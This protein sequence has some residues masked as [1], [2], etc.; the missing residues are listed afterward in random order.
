MNKKYNKYLKKLSHDFHKKY[1]DSINNRPLEN[2][3][4]GSIYSTTR[5]DFEK[6]NIVVIIDT[7]D[8]IDV[9]HNNFVTICPISDDILMAT[10]SD[11]IFLGK[12]REP[13]MFDFF[14]HCELQATVRKKDLINFLGLLNDN[15][16][17]YL[18]DFLKKKDSYQID[19]KK[20]KTGAKIIQKNDYRIK[21]QEKIAIEMEY[22]VMPSMY[23]LSNSL[24]EFEQEDEIKNII[25]GENQEKEGE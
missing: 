22:L 1:I 23:E 9:T 12:N 5:N 25:K 6:C 18:Y 7:L 21:Y 4:F 10:E 20:F 13:F 16:C 24:N 14:V 15:Q 17:R 11:L 19:T 3:K 8:D 2:F